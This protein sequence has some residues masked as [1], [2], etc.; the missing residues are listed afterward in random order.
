MAGELFRRLSTAVLVTLCL[1]ILLVVVEE[2]NAQYYWPSYYYWGKRQAGS[3]YQ[4]NGP[5]QYGGPGSQPSVLTA[6]TDN[7]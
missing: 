3:G 2:T 7:A 5:K 4:Y 6:K 1:V